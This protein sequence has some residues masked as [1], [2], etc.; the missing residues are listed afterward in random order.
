MKTSMAIPDGVLRVVLVGLVAVLYFTG[1]LSPV[2]A[3]VLGVVAVV[4]LL[5]ST[6]AR[7]RPAW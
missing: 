1:V 3:I 7:A 2:L 4:F 6:T 5:P